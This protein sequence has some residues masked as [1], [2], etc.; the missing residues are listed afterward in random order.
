MLRPVD[1]TQ[2]LEQQHKLEFG[3]TVLTEDLRASPT[4]AG[5][6]MTFGFR[7]FRPLFEPE[8]VSPCKVLL[9]N[10]LCFLGSLIKLPKFSFESV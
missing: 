3:C 4:S 10:L 6:R 7:V 8:L 2:P 1:P 5:V 9:Q